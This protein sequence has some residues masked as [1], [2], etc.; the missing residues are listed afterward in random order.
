MKNPIVTV[1]QG[2][3]KGTVDALYNGGSYLSFKG[4]PY[5]T[6]PIGALRFKA[7][8]PP[9]AWSGIHDASQHGPICPQVDM[10]TLE[11]QAGDEN[12]LFLNV[13]TP[14]LESKLPVMVY[15]HGGGFLSGSGNSDMY[16]PRFLLQNNVILVT[17]NYR[18]GMLGFLCLDTSE[19]PGNAGMKDQVAA[20]RWVHQNIANFGGDPNNVTLFGESAGAASVAYHLVS[21]MSNGLFHKVICQSGVCTVEWARDKGGRERAF[22]IGKL[23]GKH[24]QSEAELMEHLNSIPAVDIAAMSLKSSTKDER[25][26]GLPLHFV[27]VV[28]KK[29][30]GNKAFLDEDPYDI[31]KSGRVKNIPAII[32]YNSSEGLFMTIRNLKRREFYNKYPSFLVPRDM[33]EKVSTEKMHEMGNKIKKFYF[34][35]EIQEDDVEN[36]CNLLSDLHFTVPAQRFANLLSQTNPVYMYRFNCDTELNFIKTLLNVAEYKGACHADDLFYIFDSNL[37]KDLYLENKELKHIVDMIAKLWTDFA[38][39]GNP[40][41]EDSLWPPYTESQYLSI[42]STLS[43]QRQ[44]DARR[45]QFWTDLARDV[46]KSR[47]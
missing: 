2:Q 8:Q 35:D 7:P 42:D 41:P 28:E 34:G 27:P 44:A 17:V 1:K 38:K 4:I 23:L 11:L 26:R 24:T 33:A 9:K 16:G 36:F 12:C 10:Q 13:Y 19:Y 14:S 3:M 21:P 22:R 47:L 31:L 5:A 29:I 32:G 20:L 45:I 37:N 15:F 6:P 18:L 39:T 30:Q 46:P 43:V 25:Y 40:T